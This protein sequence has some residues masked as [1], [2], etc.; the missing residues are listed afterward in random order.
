VDA[1]IQYSIYYDKSLR[2]SQLWQQLSHGLLQYAYVYN[3]GI[4]WPK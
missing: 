1:K 3:N 4:L 2:F